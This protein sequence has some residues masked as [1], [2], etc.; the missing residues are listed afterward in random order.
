MVT[1]KLAGSIR[2]NIHT[3][4]ARG[5]A[6]GAVH[7]TLSFQMALFSGLAGKRWKETPGSVAFTDGTVGFQEP[8]DRNRCFN[9]FPAGALRNPLWKVACGIRGPGTKVGI[10]F[11]TKF[12]IQLMLLIFLPS[13]LA[14]AVRTEN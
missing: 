8:R 2:E 13:T 5:A 6:G 1:E 10:Y 9:R 4:L 14:T 12:K 7:R 3:F 11:P